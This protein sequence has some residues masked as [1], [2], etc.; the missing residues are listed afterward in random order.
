[1]ADNNAP[2]APIHPLGRKLTW[3][4]KDGNILL[5]IRGLGVLC[6]L[7]ALADFFVKRKPYFAVEGWFTFYAV[8]GFVAFSFIVLSTKALKRV[9]YRPEDFYGDGAVDPEAHPAHDLGVRDAGSTDG[10]EAGPQIESAPDAEGHR[11]G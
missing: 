2:D 1:M 6:L 3:V 4:E 10:S 8:I 9:L 5:L 11:N 7:L